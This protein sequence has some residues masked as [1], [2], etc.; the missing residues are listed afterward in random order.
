M[1]KHLPLEKCNH[2]CSRLQALVADTG[3]S[4][5]ATGDKVVGWSGNRR[6]V[7][8]ESRCYQVDL[9][10]VGLYSSYQG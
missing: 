9:E 6:T 5:L 4:I 8:V 3:G 1:G 10:S 7:Q 2:F